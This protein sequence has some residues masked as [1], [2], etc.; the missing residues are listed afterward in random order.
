MLCYTPFSG[1]KP[2]SSNMDVLVPVRIRGKVWPALVDTGSSQTFVQRPCLG[3]DGIGRVGLVKVKCIHGEE[4]EHQTVDIPV[5]IEGQTYL[6]NVAIMDNCPYPVVLGQ[7]VPVLADLL[8]RNL[9]SATGMVVTRAQAKANPADSTWQELPFGEVSQPVKEK[10]S[11][12]TRRREKVL[13][14]PVQESVSLP[15]LEGDVLNVPDFVQSQKDDP[16]LAKCFEKVV[17]GEEQLAR[18]AVCGKE[19]FVVRAGKLMRVSEEGEQLVVP[20]TLR[21]KVL[22]VAHSIPWAGHLGQQKTLDRIAQRFYWPGVY[23]EVVAYCKSCPTCQLTTRSHRA[24]K[25]PLVNLPIIDTP[26]TR[27]AMDVVG[28]LDK[29]RAGHRYIL[30]ISDYATRYPEA[31]PLRNTKSRQV[32]NCLLQLFSRVGVPREILTDQ[33]TNFNSKFMKQV[34]SLLGIKGIRTTPYHPQT[35]GMV[36]RFNQTL[37][38]ML[39]KFVSDTGADWDQWLPYLLFAYREVPQASTGYSPFELLYGRQV[40]GPLD[41]LREAWMGEGPAK[42]TNLISYVLKMRDKLEELSS[43]AH[44]NKEQAQSSQKTWYDRTARSRSFNPG[45]KV[46]LLLPSSESSLLAKWQGPYEVLRK[47]GPVTYEV[48]MPD[49]RKPRQVFHINLLKEWV[50]RPEPVSNAMWARAVPE[51]EELQEQYFPTARGG[52][53]CP[54]IDHLSSRH[55]AELQSIIPGG[56]FRDEPGRTAVITH[57]IQLT[58]PGPFRQTSFRV[59]ARLIPALKDEVQSMLE[60]GVIVPSRSQWCSPV[61]LVPKKDGGLRFCVDFSKLNSI[62]AF[63]PYPM[64]RVDELVERLGK[65]VY[66]STLDLCKGYWQVP[67]TPEAQE[68]TAFRAPT[69][70][71]HFTTMPFG[72]HGAAATFQ[73]LMDQVLRGAESYAAAYIDDV[74]IFSTSWADHLKHLADVF[75]RIQEAGLVVNASKC[76]LARSEVCYLGYVLGGG[77]IKPQVS[78]VDAVRSCLPP[79]TKKGVRSFLGLVGWYRRFIPEFSTRATPLTDLTKKSSP[80]KVVWTEECDRAFQ[81]L[82]DSLCHG[83]VLQSPN[84]DSPFTVQT[85]ASGLGLGAVLL[86]GVGE[87]RHPVT[88]ISRKLFPRETRYSTVE[89]ECLAIKWALDTLKYYLMGKEFVLETDHRA[90]Q[91]L[92]RMR[93][94]N[95]RITRWYLSLQP[96]KFTVQY[97]PGKDNVTADFLSRLYEEGQA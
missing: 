18:A 85:D 15:P 45:Q 49:R 86:Q 11:R 84:F 66:L 30:V 93:D 61:V 22:E 92:D 36:E 81:D 96:Y 42:P 32:A 77:T 48:A 74:V 52:D 91:W 80:N 50:S 70:L 83:P 37:K 13:G 53:T 27:I 24:T 54:S 51:E 44:S 72:L 28:P 60:M 12:S 67:L 14:T 39:R 43:L 25:V 79:T 7:D 41:V 29:S 38:A 78:K 59:P 47:M 31:F 71:F 94:S 1:N 5:E 21:P 82:K 2:T 64:P 34:Y 9:P 73:R 4:R 68:L 89:K 33:G 69:G 57:D 87:E 6:L 55:Q 17:T 56:L 8:Q 16:T 58:S 62:S 23:Q 97:K 90:L 76:Q 19:S 10:K 65:A 46:L 88:F 63:D 3:S 20:K 95:A 35:D 26:F 75:R 40:R